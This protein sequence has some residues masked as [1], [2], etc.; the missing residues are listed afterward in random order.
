[1]SVHF[2]LVVLM[3]T[4]PEISHVYVLC[5]LAHL[6]PPTN[7]PGQPKRKRHVHFWSCGLCTGGDSIADVAPVVSSSVGHLAS[8][9]RAVAGRLPPASF[10]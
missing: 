4:A 5:A 1:M 6:G 10:T 3:L 7:H 8:G 9:A 2:K